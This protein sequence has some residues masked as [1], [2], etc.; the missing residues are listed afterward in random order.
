VQVSCLGSPNVTLV[1][2]NDD[3]WCVAQGEAATSALAWTSKHGGLQRGGKKTFF[4]SPSVSSK[5][6][7]ANFRYY[8]SAC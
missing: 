4:V 8:A 2:Q 7:K 3:V 6:F 1:K 5:F